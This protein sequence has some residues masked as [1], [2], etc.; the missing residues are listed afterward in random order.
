MGLSSQ[1]QSVLRKV[2]ILTTL[3]VERM[4]KSTDPYYRLWTGDAG[5]A[6]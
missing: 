6:V 5:K 2:L 4:E 3:K 1:E